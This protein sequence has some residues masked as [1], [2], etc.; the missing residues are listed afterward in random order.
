MESVMDRSRF[1]AAGHALIAAVEADL[2]ERGLALDP[3]EE[4]CLGQAA[5]IADRLA[6]IRRRIKRDGLLITNEKSGAVRA[7]PL[8]SH[9]KGLRLDLV[10]V[11]DKISLE[12]QPEARELTRAEL[13]RKQTKGHGARERAKRARIAAAAAE[14]S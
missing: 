1:E 7:N 14:D 13:F 5:D 11:L 2:V 10:R 12:P 6:G 8:L 4:A 3:V 9:E